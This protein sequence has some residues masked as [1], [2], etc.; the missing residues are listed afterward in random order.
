MKW[1]KASRS[2]VTPEDF[3][4]QSYMYSQNKHHRRFIREGRYCKKEIG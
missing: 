4:G 2:E 3:I 1:S